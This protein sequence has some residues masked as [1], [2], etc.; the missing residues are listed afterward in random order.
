MDIESIL[1]EPVVTEKT[2]AMREE[3][4]VKYVFRVLPAANKLQVMDAVR[5]IFNVKPVSCNVA[6]VK[7]KTKTTRTKSGQREG[8]KSA[9][10]KAIV[11]LSPGEKI[12]IFEGV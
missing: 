8:Q 4:S 1:I 3:K 12:D 7:S 10:K 6:W 9:W 11:T 2:N 5:K